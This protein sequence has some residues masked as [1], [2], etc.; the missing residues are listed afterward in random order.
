LP[1]VVE[2]IKY[3]HE[4]L[5]E[6]SLGVAVNVDVS[7]QEARYRELYGL[8]K[9]KFE[10]LLVELR[11]L[12]TRFPELKAAIDL[13]EKWLIDWDRLAQFQ[14]IVAVEKEKVVEVEHNVPVLVPTRDT[15]SIRT[16]L[17]N[18]LLIE[19]LV[20]E[21]RRLK[22][23]NPNLRFNLDEDV[24]LIFFSEL[25]GASLPNNL[26]EELASQL[27]SYTDSMYRKFTNIGGSWT[28]DH[29][30]MLST[31]LQERFTLANLIRNANVEIEKARQVAD[32]RLE[33]L[34][35]YKLA[36]GSFEQKYKA[37]ESEL[38]R[39]VADPQFGRYSGSI[40]KLFG[41][42]NNFLGSEIRTIHYE[43]EPI[44]VLGEIH[45][46]D[47]NF[48][49]L[50]SLMRERDAEN[51][52]LREKLIAIQ[53]DRPNITNISNDQ[54]RTIQ[55]LRNEINN[56]NNQLSTLRTQSQV[57]VNI[58]ANTQE[59]E[60]KIRTLNSRIQELESQLRT[61]RIDYE[62]QIR[63]AKGDA[64]KALRESQLKLSD[65]ERKVSNLEREN[66]SLKKSTSDFERR[67]ADLTAIINSRGGEI[68]QTP[69]QNLTNSGNL[70]KAS[71]VSGT[72]VT[73]NFETPNYNTGRQGTYGTTSSG[74]SNVS[75]A[76]S[77]YGVSGTGATGSYGLSGSGVGL[78]TSYGDAG[79]SSATYSSRPS[80]SY[81]T[82]SG[83]ATSGASGVTS[84]V[85]S[86][87]TGGINRPGSLTG[88]TTTYGAGTLS[89]SGLSGSGVSSGSGLAS[90][91]SFG[92]TGASSYGVSGT[93]GVSGANLTSSV[94]GGVSG[95]L[96]SS[97]RVVSGTT[98]GA[99]SLGGASSA[100]SSVSGS[101]GT[102]SSTY[103]PG[104]YASYRR[105]K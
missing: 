40:S 57:N 33:G 59:Y 13:I 75:G 5:E 10:V 46:I 49:R 71:N 65:A 58:S 25:G 54:N 8:M 11:K 72:T 76:S 43:E 3:V 97:G 27:R 26:S 4:I 69:T 6:E 83:T 32:K 52:L 48:L 88:A 21:L 84:G 77:G 96:T 12:R 16:D 105:D 9:P 41:D 86:S 36:T 30:L 37:L 68:P 64:E 66:A 51:R 60:I 100:S 74:S 70:G 92:T 28:T 15:L 55:N 1:Q 61:V 22:K 56:L 101:L 99:T 102:S 87:V 63:N 18:S 38:N 62:G 7:I 19:K 29:E 73:S 35:K 94:T 31:I 2:V 23:E 24:Q 67:V 47:G 80:G 53:K 95:G 90:S 85:S 17:A 14:R 89:S 78:S 98:L 44:Y 34:R 45:G 39:I 104:S 91:G 20:M 50:E 79:S 93:Y 42:F 82:V 103:T 81:G